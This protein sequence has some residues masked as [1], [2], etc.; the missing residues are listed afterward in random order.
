MT[1]ADTST[2]VEAQVERSAT[3]Q[4]RVMPPPISRRALL[5]GAATAVPT[6]LTLHSGA[7]LANASNLMIGGSS[8]QNNTGTRVDIN[9]PQDHYACLAT[10]GQTSGNYNFIDG[11]PVTLVPANVQFKD[12]TTN[13]WVYGDD[14][15]ALGGDFKYKGNTYYVRKGMLLSATAYT[16]LTTAGVIDPIRLLNL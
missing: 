16:S 2:H 11:N 13:S 1:D 3:D 5:R 15:C 14:M 7:A 4:G 12:E 8:G 6:I 9:A 10:T